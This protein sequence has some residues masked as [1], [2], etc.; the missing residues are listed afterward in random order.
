MKVHPLPRYIA[1]AATWLIWRRDAFGP[2][3][4][5]LKQLIIDTH[6]ATTDDDT[7]APSFPVSPTR[8]HFTQL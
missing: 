3:V 4:E 7:V 1:N 2:N 8:P 5:A 6:N